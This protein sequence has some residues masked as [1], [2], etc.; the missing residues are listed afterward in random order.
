MRSFQ[1]FC[2]NK[3]ALLIGAALAFCS[4]ATSAQDFPTG[5][6]TLVV[7]YAAGGNTDIMARLLA[8]SLGQEFGQT[9]VVDNKGGAGGAIAAE[10]VARANPDGYTLFFGANAQVS[11]V[12]RVQRVKYDPIK[13]FRPVSIYGTNG[14]IFAVSS[15]VPVNTIEEFIAY[16]KK[17]PNQINYGSGGIGT[18]AHLASAMFAARAGVQLQHV[19]YKGGSQTMTDLMAGHIQMYLGNTS[20]ILP[21]LG[22]KEIKMLAVTSKE[23]LK[24]LPNVPS[25]SET[26]PGY[27]I[28]AWNG[29]LAPAGVPKQIIDRLEAAAIKSAKNPDVIAKL[30]RLGIVARGTTAAEHQKIIEAEE[31]FFAD[32]VKTAGIKPE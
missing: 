19:P 26:L 29:V 9:I 23:R 31:V 18:I 2:A 20:E 25:I 22:R 5:P 8:E 7:P 15:Q 3:R 4:T 21:M 6:I 32:A 27:T 17:N 11:V 30:A 28:E 12:P 24:E 1:R 10:Y 14:A 13:A 16:A